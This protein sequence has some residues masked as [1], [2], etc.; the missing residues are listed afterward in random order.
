MKDNSEMLLEIKEMAPD[1]K[2]PRGLLLSG[3]PAIKDQFKEYLFARD[4]DKPNE[5]RPKNKSVTS[6]GIDKMQI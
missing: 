1:G 5:K 2:I 3:K 4:L 6:K